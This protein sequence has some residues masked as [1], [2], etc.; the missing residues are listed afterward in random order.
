[1]STLEVRQ[2]CDVSDFRPTLTLLLLLAISS[3]KIM[4]PIDTVW[5]ETAAA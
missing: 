1:M 3:H 2:F 4:I 5:E